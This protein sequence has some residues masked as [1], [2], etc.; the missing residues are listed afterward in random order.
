[1]RASYGFLPERAYFTGRVELMQ[2]LLAP[3]VLVIDQLSKWWITPQAINPGVGFGALRTVPQL[4]L[5]LAFVAAVGLAWYGF[6]Q[7][8]EFSAIRRAGF[9]LAL[10][11]AMS[12][13]IDRVF[14]GAVTDIFSPLSW[15]PSFNVADCGIVIGLLLFVAGFDDYR[16]PRRRRP[17][18]IVPR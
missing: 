12:N 5:V 4:A 7:Y 6:V 18:S 16:R 11:G 13:L 1:M 10:G 17:G 14:H 9:W 8:H 3:L 2:F 15:F